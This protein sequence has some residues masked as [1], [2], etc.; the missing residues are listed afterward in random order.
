MEFQVLP[1]NGKNIDANLDIIT[2][3][4][5]QLTEEFRRITWTI[6]FQ[7]ESPENS[8][9]YSY[10]KFWIAKQIAHVT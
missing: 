1:G 4:G 5:L 9:I 8:V 7:G 2:L 6:I 10:V 3:M